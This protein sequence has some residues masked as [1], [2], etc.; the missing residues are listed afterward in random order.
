MNTINGVHIRRPDIVRAKSRN[1]FEIGID[2]VFP[3][4]SIKGILPD[5]K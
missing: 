5:V 4:R 1:R 3:E 2:E